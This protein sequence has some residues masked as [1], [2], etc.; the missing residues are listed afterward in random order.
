VQKEKLG[1]DREIQFFPVEQ[2]KIL[3]E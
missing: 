3:A 1:A 2:A